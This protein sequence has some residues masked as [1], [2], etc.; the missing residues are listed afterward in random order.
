MARAEGPAV[1]RDATGSLS[2]GGGRRLDVTRIL[3]VVAFAGSLALIAWGIS[4]R[5][6]SQ[7][8]ILVT[9]LV[10]LALTFAALAIAGAVAAYRS[11]RAGSVGRAFW[12]ALLG[13]AAAVAAWGCLAGAAVLALLYA[14]R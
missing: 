7:V 13:G 11:G 8:P 12:A 2:P 10:V 4:S 1:R 14:P 5:S 9:G 3:F 6:D